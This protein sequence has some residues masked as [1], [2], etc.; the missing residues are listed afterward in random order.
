MA[1]H[2]CNPLGL[3]QVMFIPTI[4]RQGTK[5]IIEKFVQKAQDCEVIGT[6]AQTEMGH[7]KILPYFLMRNAKLF[8]KKKICIKGTGF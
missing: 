4:Q 7:G 5:R 3:H 6:Y 2:E 1:A 8:S